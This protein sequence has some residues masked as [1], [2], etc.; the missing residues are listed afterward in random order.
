M[1][2]SLFFGFHVGRAGKESEERGLRDFKGQERGGVI[3]WILSNK[4]S[5]SQSIGLSIGTYHK[6]SGHR[7][8]TTALLASKLMNAPKN[9][10]RCFPAYPNTMP[11]GAVLFLWCAIGMLLLIVIPNH[12]QYQVC[13][14]IKIVAAELLL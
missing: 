8:T 10:I 3:S 1:F 11:D 4:N 5:G 7:V 9:I 6:A 2:L 12:P 14:F 13:Y